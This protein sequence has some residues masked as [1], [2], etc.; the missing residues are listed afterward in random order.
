MYRAEGQIDPVLPQIG[1]RIT[2][3]FTVFAKSASRNLKSY[4]GAACKIIIII[5]TNL[6]ILKISDIS[7]SDNVI[8]M[9]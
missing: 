7:L 4:P 5:I 2:F 1:L 6:L 3:K 8:T 9:V